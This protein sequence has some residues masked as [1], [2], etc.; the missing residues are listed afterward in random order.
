MLG[1]APVTARA[2][3][4]EK[5]ATFGGERRDPYQLKESWRL[6]QRARSFSQESL[7]PHHANAARAS[8]ALG[9]LPQVVQLC[10]PDMRLKEHRQDGYF[11]LPNG[12][13][14]WVGGLDDDDRVEK[15]LG[16]RI[17]LS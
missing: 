11:A 9:T 15:I 7:L 8:I 5:A 17:C 13:R 1:H 14:V 2:S 16:A 6:S 3:R 4:C 12:S 10:F